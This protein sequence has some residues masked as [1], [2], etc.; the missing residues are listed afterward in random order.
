MFSFKADDASFLNG[1]WRSA[2]VHGAAAGI[3]IN[4]G[5]GCEY[6]SAWLWV[7]G[8]AAEQFFESVDPELSPCA[9]GAAVVSG[10]PDDDWAVGQLKIC[11][12]GGEIGDNRHAVL[13]AA[14]RLLERR[15]E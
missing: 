3:A 13:A 1:L 12:V 10:G 7:V 4:S 2:F 5:C 9:A 6:Q 14:V 15:N 8:E 11:G